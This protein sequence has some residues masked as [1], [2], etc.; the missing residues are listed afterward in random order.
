MKRVEHDARERD[1]PYFP[2]FLKRQ[3]LC[4]SADPRKKELVRRKLKRRM[5]IDTREDISTRLA[6]V[7]VVA[8][9]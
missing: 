5:E 8:S 1:Y 3:P 4:F 6:P 2:A 9:E 7:R